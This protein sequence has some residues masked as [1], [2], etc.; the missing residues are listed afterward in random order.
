MRAL[1]WSRSCRFALG[2]LLLLCGCGRSQLPRG[3]QLAGAASSGPHTDT[4]TPCGSSGT[5]PG[6]P[7]SCLLGYTPPALADRP[8]VSVE[9]IARSSVGR[10]TPATSL[11]EGAGLAVA[12]RDLLEVRLGQTRHTLLSGSGKAEILFVRAGDHIRLEGKGPAFL[13]A[14]TGL[15]LDFV[16]WEDK[17]RTLFGGYVCLGA[18]LLYRRVALTVEY[19]SNVSGELDGEGSLWTTSVV[20]SAGAR[21]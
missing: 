11:G 2:G 15:T 5:V 19:A 4:N 20:L 21:F 3:P 13:L 8:L 9:W 17:S 16:S 7:I 12:V 1:S 10:N 18:G 14:S 6:R